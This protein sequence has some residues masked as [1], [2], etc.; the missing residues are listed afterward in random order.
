MAKKP[1]YFFLF[2]KLVFV[3][4]PSFVHLILNKTLNWVLGLFYQHVFSFTIDNPHPQWAPGVSIAPVYHRDG[5]LILMH[6]T[7]LLPVFLLSTVHEFRFTLTIVYYTIFLWLVLCI[8][9]LELY[10]SRVFLWHLSLL[11]LDDLIKKSLASSRNVLP[12]RNSLIKSSAI[13][14]EIDTKTLLWADKTLGNSG[15]CIYL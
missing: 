11:R 2:W 14:D 1:L 10:L 5:L 7:C 3:H 13:S 9:V 12:A 8:L 15:G 4:L 6:L